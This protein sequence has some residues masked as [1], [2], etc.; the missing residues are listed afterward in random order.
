MAFDLGRVQKDI[1]KLRRFLK[2]APKHATP[3]KVHSQRTAIRRFEAAMQA[4]E[5]DSDANVQRLLRKLAKLRKRAGK[6]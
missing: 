3:K 2:Q 1:R 6:V 5:L 4:L